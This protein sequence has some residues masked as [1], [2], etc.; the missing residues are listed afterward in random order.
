MRFPRRLVVTDVRIAAQWYAQVFAGVVAELDDERARL[1]LGQEGVALELN[2]GT[3][4]PDPST[5]VLELG[6]EDLRS[7]LDAALAAGARR[8]TPDSLAGYAQFRDPSG[9]L[10]ALRERSAS[11]RA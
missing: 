6:V 7:W 3:P 2:R 8:A 1:E 5:P 9:Y 4:T 10:W 11:P